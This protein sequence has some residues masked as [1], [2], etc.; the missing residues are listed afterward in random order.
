MVGRIFDSLGALRERRDTLAIFLSDNGFVQGRS[1]HRWRER[2]GRASAFPTRPR[3]SSVHD[4]LARSHRGRFDRTAA[5]RH[6]RHRSH[7]ARGG[8]RRSR[9]GSAARRTPAAFRGARRALLEYRRLGKGPFPTWAST[10]TRALQYIEYYAETPDENLPR[11]L[12]PA[13]RPVAAHNLLRDR[14]PSNNPSLAALQ[15]QLAADRD[16]AGTQGAAPAQ[17]SRRFAPACEAP[18][19]G[20]QPK[21]RPRSSARRPF[22]FGEAVFEAGPEL[23]VDRRVGADVSGLV[24]RDSGPYAQEREDLRE[25]LVRPGEEVLRRGIR[26]ARARNR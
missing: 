3:S 5:D 18:A 12:R 2:D 24:A 8:R 7:R 23:R 13:P 17:Q 26:T 21:S 10:R 14:D 25:R 19:M 9:S 15:A 16:C 22:R 4:P 1:R 11:V 6:R 20:A